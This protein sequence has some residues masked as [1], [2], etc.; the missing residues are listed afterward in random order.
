MSFMHENK[1]RTRVSRTAGKMEAFEVSS[2]TALGSDHI[3]RLRVAERSEASI[4][5]L[6]TDCK[7]VFATR[8]KL[9]ECASHRQRKGLHFPNLLPLRGHS[10]TRVL[11]VCIQMIAVHAGTAPVYFQN[12]PG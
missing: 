3:C 2:L 6:S 12:A 4:D 5:V 8:H 9:S 7:I 11:M 10:G 1:P